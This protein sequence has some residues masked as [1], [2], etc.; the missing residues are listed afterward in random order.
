MLRLKRSVLGL[1]APRMELVTFET[2]AKGLLEQAIHRY[3]EAQDTYRWLQPRM[4]SQ[5]RQEWKLVLKGLERIC[6][7]LDAGYEPISPPAWPHGL[8]PSYLGVIPRKVRVE[9]MRA[10]R[11][12]GEDELLVYDPHAHHFIEQRDQDP[13]LVGVVRVGREERVHFLIARW[14]LQGDLSLLFGGLEPKGR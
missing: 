10:S 11:I 3:N 2:P 9:A 14:D 12:F 13:M 7:A 4:G 5:V 6:R 8:L 1:S